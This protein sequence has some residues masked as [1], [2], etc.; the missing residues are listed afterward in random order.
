MLERLKIGV[1]GVSWEAFSRIL[2]LWEALGSLL[3]ASWSLLG[4]IWE[5]WEAP[6]RSFRSSWGLLDASWGLLERSWSLL[7]R[8]W[9]PLGDILRVFGE[10][11]GPILELGRHLRSD[12]MK[13]CETIKNIAKY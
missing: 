2:E 7:G 6:R 5:L 3:E 13:F 4:V 8:S 12:L 9:E 1:L 11:F 10:D